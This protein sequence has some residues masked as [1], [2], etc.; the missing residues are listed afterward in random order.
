MN[1]LNPSTL[2][3]REARGLVR[4]DDL[5]CV[6]PMMWMLLWGPFGVETA[7]HA[8]EALDFVALLED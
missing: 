4:F 7:N 2:G 3:V 8:V 6:L 1:W 5:L